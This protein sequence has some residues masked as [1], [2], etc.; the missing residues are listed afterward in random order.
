MTTKTRKE[1]PT[2][3]RLEFGFTRHCQK[4]GRCWKVLLRHRMDMLGYITERIRLVMGM[5]IRVVY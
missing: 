4:A 1:L 3:K 5:S 2:L